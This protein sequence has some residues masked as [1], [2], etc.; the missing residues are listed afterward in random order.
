[1]HVVLC[2]CCCFAS[3]ICS[4]IWWS[5]T[6]PQKMP[7]AGCGRQDHEALEGWRSNWHIF[8]LLGHR[9]DYQKAPVWHDMIGAYSFC[10][11]HI[12]ILYR[13]IYHYDI[14]IY[15]CVFISWIIWDIECSM[16]WNCLGSVRICRRTGRFICE[17]A[18]REG[19][20]ESFVQNSLHQKGFPYVS[21]AF[22]RSLTRRRK[23]LEPLPKMEM[24][25]LSSARSE[26]DERMVSVSLVAACC[27]GPRRTLLALSPPGYVWGAERW[28]RHSS[29][30]SVEKLVD[31]WCFIPNGACIGRNLIL[32]FT[33]PIGC[34][35][36]QICLGCGKEQCHWPWPCFPSINARHIFLA[37]DEEYSAAN[38]EFG[39]QPH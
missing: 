30:C 12:Y 15:T 11:A 13:W 29:R 32:I 6:A 21:M 22:E 9:L 8:L 24:A 39:R 35:D 23:H 25:A 33:P 34:L 28:S 17:N 20:C 38:A 37:L 7:M 5:K 4:A 14:Y 3:W 1:M 26:W 19:S 2:E 10:I 31:W 36:Q 18:L 16:F 27:R